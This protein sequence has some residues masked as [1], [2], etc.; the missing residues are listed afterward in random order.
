MSTRESDNRS[1]VGIERA[2][3]EDS[4]ICNR[5]AV[6]GLHADCE[7]PWHR[8]TSILRSFTM[9]S[10]CTSERHIA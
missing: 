6:L 5:L 9:P 3:V 7:T 8:E 1:E 2:E 4:G 10:S